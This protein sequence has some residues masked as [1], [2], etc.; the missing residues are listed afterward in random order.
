MVTNSLTTWDK[1]KKQNFK[2]F[3]IYTLC[4]MERDDTYH[5]FLH[6]PR[7]VSIVGG[8]KGGLAA[9]GAYPQY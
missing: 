4:G 1:K 8:D 7:G 5:I 9:E 2:V 6:V 3:D